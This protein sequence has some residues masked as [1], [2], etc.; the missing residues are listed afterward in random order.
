MN[1]LQNRHTACTALHSRGGAPVAS[2]QRLH[3]DAP[4]LELAL[5][6]PTCSQTKALPACMRSRL[7]LPSPVVL[8]AGCISD[9][10]LRRVTVAR[11]ALAAPLCRQRSHVRRVQ[12]R[13]GA[14]SRLYR[15][16]TS[17][18]YVV[19]TCAPAGL[20]FCSLGKLLETNL[21]QSRHLTL[22]PPVLE[23]LL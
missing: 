8:T 1:H 5:H 19:R 23:A 21:A 15:R 4:P 6:I 14:E 17:A 18:A 11:K 2:L 3:A 22:S 12:E 16:A 20:A 13:S 9:S 7:D 10:G